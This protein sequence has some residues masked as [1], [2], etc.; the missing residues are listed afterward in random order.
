MWRWI[1]VFWWSLAQASGGDTDLTRYVNP[2]IG[3]GQG[4]PDY[5]MGNS[6]GNTPP[7][8]SFP[9]GMALWSP[10]TTNQ[11]G[12]YRFEHSAIRGFSLTHFSGRGISCWQDLPFMP[13]AAP[14]TTSPGSDWARYSSNF[15]HA[16]E[17]APDNERAAPGF[18]GVKLDNGV[19]VELT[20]TQRTGSARFTFP[21]SGNGTVLVNTGGSANGNWGNTWV[22]VNGDREVYGAV[23]SGDCGGSFSYTVHFVACFDQPFVSTGAWSGPDIAPDAKE[24]AGPKSGVFLT[25]DTGSNSVVN[26]KVGLSFV[27][28]TNA[29]ENLIAEN[30]G[31]DFDQ[32]RDRA[33]AAWNRRLRCIQVGSGPDS[34]DRATLDQKTIFYTAL[35][36]AS[37]HPSTFSDVNGEYLGFDG[38]V[39]HTDRTQYHNIP[40]WDFYR[41]LAPLLAI[42]APDVA[43][44]L[45]QSLVNDA[46]QDPGGGMPR[47]VH[48]ATDSCGMFGDGSSKV[49]ATTYAFGAGDFDARGA[50]AAMIRGGTQPG[51]TSAGCPVRDGLADY[52]ELGYVSTAIGG[53]VSRTLEYAT[54]DF[55]IAQLAKS[56]GDTE[57]YK[58]FLT[59]AQNWRNLVNNSYIVPRRQDGSFVSDV[60]PDGCVGDGFIEGSEGQYGFMVRFNAVGLFDAMGS[61]NAAV[62]RLDRHFQQLNAGPCS[63]FAFMGNEVSLKTPWMY[64]FAGQPWKTQ[65]VVRRIL[66]ELYSSSPDGMPGNDDGGVLSSWVV[67]SSIGLYP[68]ISGV[69]G[70]VVGSP[71]FPQ[72]TIALASGAAIQI[73]AP[74]T[75]AERVYIQRMTVN[76]Q[77]YGSSWIPWKTISSGGKIDFVLGPAPNPNWGS[78]SSAVPPSFEVQNVP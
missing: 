47:W 72:V 67:L 44:D 56:L 68:E 74:E 1:I 65:A 75:S 4:A 6:A 54:S 42:T 18:Y 71:V 36:H 45:S 32:V 66:A 48:A 3:T 20:V 25:F 46:Q 26:A 53:S 55:S 76:G 38:R 2:F 35:Y 13:A 60:G 50:L 77:D 30:P 59:R 15:S 7:G 23:T 61:R 28:F 43:S 22:K 70:F 12:G 8:A 5:S 41:S 9:F 64:A 19:A 62:A 39:H 57:T 29:Y 17:A 27:S 33:N 24:A 11:S 21:G 10:D 40:A 52:L 69:G 34:S 51:T 31:W 16:T 37:I 49:V 58:T 73:N 14:V 78:Q 63:E